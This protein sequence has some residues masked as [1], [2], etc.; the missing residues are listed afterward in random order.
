MPR[1]RSIRLEASRKRIPARIFIYSKEIH[2]QQGNSY[3]A[4]KF[5]YSKSAG[6]IHLPALFLFDMSRHSAFFASMRQ[7]MQL[8]TPREAAMAVKIDITI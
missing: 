8:V 5:I 6:R 2:I 7:D 3:T 1:I 4:R